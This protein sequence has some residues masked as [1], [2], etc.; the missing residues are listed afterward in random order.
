MSHRFDMD[1]IKDV[2]AKAGTTLRIE[3]P[4]TKTHPV[5]AA[6][7]TVDGDS[8]DDRAVSEV[9]EATDLPMVTKCMY[10]RHT[11]RGPADSDRIQKF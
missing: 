8:V 5:P 7:W 2:V 11:T 1:G 9:S 6:L 3:V 10:I 4:F